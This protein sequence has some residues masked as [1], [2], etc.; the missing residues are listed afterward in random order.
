MVTAKRMMACIGLPAVVALA[1]ALTSQYGFGLHPCD[2]CIYQ[3]I[4]YAI[5]IVLALIGVIVSKHR[6]LLGIILVLAA[7]LYLIDGG[8][9]V[10]HAGVE[11]G[12][13]EGPDSCSFKAGGGSLED[14]RNRLMNAPLVS[15]KDTTFELFG[16]SM[17]GWNV[18]YAFAGALLSAKLYL[19]FR[20][21][22]HG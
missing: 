20:K 10:Y 11:W 13:F 15:C 5:I 16:L 8:I 14:I 18:L 22:A 3:R 21:P 2:L 7:L 12:I 17:A 19:R 4:P 9:A 1:G 6:G